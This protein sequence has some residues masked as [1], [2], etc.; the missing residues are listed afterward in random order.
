MDWL[1]SLVFGLIS[2]ITEFFPVSQWAHGALLVKM[3]GRESVS[4]LWM[5]SSHLAALLAVIVFASAGWK[6]ILREQRIYRAP[7]RR[8]PRPADGK[9]I[10]QYRMLKTAG[11]I[12]AAAMV[13]T[14]KMGPIAGNLGWVSLL[15]LLNGVILF[16][17]ERFHKGNKDGRS[18]AAVDGILVGLAGILGVFPGISF[19]GCV[20][21]MLL[22]RGFET[23]YAV[24][25]SLLLMMPALAGCILGDLVRLLS[26]GIAGFSLSMAAQ[27][28]L[29]AGST[30]VGAFYAINGMRRMA[31]KTG[32][33]SFPYYSWGLALFIFI[34][35]LTV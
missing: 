1:K 28:L 31:E 6:R 16:S 24:E 9:V 27:C 13:L 25:N 18:I 20:L 19:M 22:L 3:F 33:T 35:Y 12:A 29:I 8:R 21:W 26:A 32:F 11:I 5:L 30:F 10:A 23:V 15:L 2:G 17:A 34:L 14:A 4:E 7:S